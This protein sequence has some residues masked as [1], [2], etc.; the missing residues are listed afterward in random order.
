MNT[1]RARRTV[2][3]IS[4]QLSVDNATP[5]G[6]Q[7]TNVSGVISPF[8]CKKSPLPRSST[9]VQVQRNSSRVRRRSP[10]CHDVLEFMLDGA[11]M[12]S[13]ESLDVTESCDSQRCNQVASLE[14]HTSEPLGCQQFEANSMDISDNDESGSD[15]SGDEDSDEGF[16]GQC[17]GMSLT[18]TSESTA[19]CSRSQSH[20]SSKSNSSNSSYGSSTSSESAL[21]WWRRHFKSKPKTQPPAA[22]FTNSLLRRS[23]VSAHASRPRPASTAG[24]TPILTKLKRSVS[25]KSAT[26]LLPTS[27]SKQAHAAA[28]TA[29][30]QSKLARASFISGSLLSRSKTTK[31]SEIMPV[32]APAA[33]AKSALSAS[34][35]ETRS[36]SNMP[37]QTHSDSI[38]EDTFV[39]RWT[40]LKCKGMENLHVVSVPARC[41]SLNHKDAFLFYPCLFHSLDAAQYA[42]EA[43]NISA[44]DTANNTL[45]AKPA[46]G[47]KRVH[48]GTLLAQEYNRR[49]SVYSLASRTIYIWLGAHA[50][51]I[52]RDAITRVAMEIRDKELMSKAAIVVVDESAAANS[53]RKQF[54]AQ[55]H[56]AETG[57]GHMLTDELSAMCSRITP[58]SRAGDDMDFEK[59]LQRRKVMYGF[60]EAI[61]PAT[62]IAADTYVN[63]AALQKVPAGGA[64]ILDTWSDVF[65]WWRNEPC[66]PAVRRCAVNFANMLVKDASIPPRPQSASVWYEVQGF[67]H[68]IFKTKFPDWPFVFASSMG[69]A[70]VVRQMVSDSA[71]P[72]LALPVRSISRHSRPVAVV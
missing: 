66:N 21:T 34:S 3:H 32:P 57:A 36:K 52:K 2:H 41:E 7:V 27:A 68:V 25:S 63:A 65:I 72:P 22:D 50:S 55:L 16:D 23:T 35:N 49:K 33:L 51:A 64:I 12:S 1:T 14:P 56:R 46:C 10:L 62:I 19:E 26:R 60:W 58:L 5:S 8:H 29:Q 44:A 18:A 59:A 30:Q 6:E 69:A 4:F 13:Q 24:N 53:A 54:F 42:A 28:D 38:P 17:D 70:E 9:L 61:P 43:L 47:T 71:P 40:M 45:T 39:S 48:G 67:E 20:R 37:A 31:A 15:V 11:S